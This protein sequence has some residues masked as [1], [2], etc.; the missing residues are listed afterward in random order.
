[1]P[2]CSTGAYSYLIVTTI[3]YLQQ[4]QEKEASL[5]DLLV[6]SNMT[7]V[8]QISHV[9]SAMANGIFML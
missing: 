2:L 8:F 3:C 1:M 7:G 6:G 4:F 5:F 9:K